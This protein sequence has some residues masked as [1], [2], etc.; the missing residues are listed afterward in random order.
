M[1]T[2]PY[3]YYKRQTSTNKSHIKK[4]WKKFWSK[5]E[6]KTVQSLTPQLQSLTTQVQNLNSQNQKLKDKI[7]NLLQDPEYRKYMLGFDHLDNLI[8]YIF[9]L[10]PPT[11]Q[12]KTLLDYMHL[13]WIFVENTEAKQGV[14]YSHLKN[15]QYKSACKLSNTYLKTHKSLILQEPQEKKLTQ[16]ITDIEDYYKLFN[17]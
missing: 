2:P 17:I 12:Y 15:Q 7:Q 13:D 4:A 10:P 1:P 9:N 14:F 8:Q 6:N 11:Q 3:F 5:P 16:I